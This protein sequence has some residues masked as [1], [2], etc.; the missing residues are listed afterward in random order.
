MAKGKI[1]PNHDEEDRTAKARFICSLYS[2]GNT[3]ESSCEQCGIHVRTFYNWIRDHSD[4]A[5]LYKK[6]KYDYAI[7]QKRELRRKAESALHRLAEGYTKTETTTE[8]TRTAKGAVEKTVTKH[9][10]VDPHPTIVMY[11]MNNTNNENINPDIDFTHANTVKHE[12]EV[13]IV[14]RKTPNDDN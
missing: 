3:I 13:V 1:K 14:K 7:T 10:V 4:I 6:A 8:V 12:G 5:E 9:I 2:D 11:V